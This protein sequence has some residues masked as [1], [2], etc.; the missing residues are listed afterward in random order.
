MNSQRCRRGRRVCNESGSILGRTLSLLGEIWERQ[1]KI[2]R[3]INETLEKSG[4]ERR[5]GKYP[6]SANSN[7]VGFSPFGKLFICIKLINFTNSHATCRLSTLLRSK[8]P[9]ERWAL[10]AG[11]LYLTLQI[12]GRDALSTKRSFRH[13]SLYLQC[14]RFNPG[15]SLGLRKAGYLRAYYIGARREHTYLPVPEL[16]EN[17]C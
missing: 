15:R 14:P 7:L 13:S 11:K 4:K 8:L 10:I 9:P 2:P 6:I 16:R 12:N 5:E 17:R 1:T 3:V